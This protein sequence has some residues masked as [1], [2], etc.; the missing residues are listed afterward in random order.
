MSSVRV[1]TGPQQEPVTLA[2]ARLWA[3]IDAD[4][5][6]QD[7]MVML[8]VG[9][10]REYA[11][12]ITGRSFIQRTLE[13]AY[14]CFPSHVINLPYPPLVSVSSISYLDTDGAWQVFSGGSP[15]EFQVDTYHEPG[16]VW[17]LYLESWP[18]TRTELNAVRIRY[19]AG[20]SGP[21]AIP[22][23]LKIWMQA[24]I[25][26]LYENREQIIVGTSVNDLPRAYVDGLLDSLVTADRIAG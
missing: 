17:P 14:D 25:T 24:R 7:A 19:V 2:E 15:S 22:R 16:M 12:N 11:E 4:D 13:V 9:A 26:T 18:N 5:T 3:R 21:S 23:A 6:S 8:L 1:V 20:Y 10:M